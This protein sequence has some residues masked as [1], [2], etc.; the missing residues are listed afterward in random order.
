[1]A[2]VGEHAAAVRAPRPGLRALLVGLA[3][4]L[5]LAGC[6]GGDGSGASAETET[7]TVQSERGPV[8]VPAAPQRIAVLSGSLAGDLFTLEAP[9]VAADPRVL[10]VQADASGFPPSWSARAQQQGTQRLAS[11][12]AGLSIEQVAAARPDLIIGGGQG[13][14]AAQAANAYPQ[15][16]EIAPTVLLPAFTQWQDQLGR[17]AE[18]V[19]R[20]DR[21]P[22]LLQAYQDRAAQVRGA[23]RL[24]PQPTVFLYQARD[25]K[26]YVITPTAALPAIARDLGFVPDDVITKADNPPLFGTGDSFETSPELLPRVADAPTAI[27]LPIGQIPLDQ[28]RTNPVYAR[29]PAFASGNAYELPST[30]FRPDYQ[31]AMSTLDTFGTLFR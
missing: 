7:R 3:A 20:T 28:L 21:V 17:I 27:V 18:V 4:L 14:T 15:L 26:P 22:G 30:S 5:V 13:F 23:L 25:G 19:G 16:Q 2:P 12:G 6:G 10:G 8:Q 31:G 11:E 24:P 29:L 1:M 9:V